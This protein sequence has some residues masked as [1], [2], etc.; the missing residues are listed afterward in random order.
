MLSVFTHEACLGHDLPEGASRAHVERPERLR[1]AR[2]GV[3]RFGGSFSVEQASLVDRDRLTTVH[4]PEHVHRVE[5]AC[6]AGRWLD[7]DTYARAESWE[8]A[9]ASAGAALQAAWEA[10]SEGAAFSL[11]RPPGHHARPSG[12]MGFCLFN[13]VAVAAEALAGEG[14]RVA[15]VDV[16]VHHGNGTQEIFYDRGDV[17]FV[18][19]HQAPFYPG[20]GKAHEVGG[21][22]GE[23]FTVN[24]PVPE[25]TGHAGWLELVDRVVEPVVASFGPDV[26]L[27]SAG[28]DAHRGDPVGGLDLVAGTF[29]AA[30]ERLRAI[31]PV[32]C[33]LEGGYSLEALERCVHAVAAALVGDPDPVKETLVEGVRPWGMLRSEVRSYHAGRWPVDVSG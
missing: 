33:V 5:Q 11:A 8:A 6:E 1:A 7:R 20:T 22:P 2:A 9:C 13:N 15:I 12:A 23:G 26:V 32:A 3:E 31:A 18:S 14:K 28:F 21:G 24:L 25:G 30:V 19:V 4:A 16:D 10:A 27:V 17:L 29:H